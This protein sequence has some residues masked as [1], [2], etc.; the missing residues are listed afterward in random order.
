MS[1][2]SRYSAYD[3]ELLAIYATIVKFRHMLE[4]RSFKIYT[5]Q[6]PLTSAFFKAKDPISNRQ[7]HQLA[8]ISEFAT[9][10]A[11]IPGLDNVVPDA[12]SRQYDDEVQPVVVHTVVHTLADL[13]LA[14]IAR[15][16]PPI[17]EEQPSSLQLR[18]LTFPGLEDT[19]ICEVSLVRPLILVP[20]GWRR[21]IFDAL[22]ELANPSGKA[23][24]AIVAKAY[25]WRNMRRDVLQWARQCRTCAVSKVAK[26]ARPE[27]LPVSVPAK[28]FTHVHVDIV[29]P[30]SPN[31]GHRY[32]LT[33]VDRTTRWPEPIPM[34]DTTADTVLQAFMNGWVSR[35]GIPITVATDRGAQFTS[36]AW[37]AAMIRLGVTVTTTTAYHPQ[38]NGMVERF[39]R[40]MKNALRCAVRTNNSWSKALPWVMLGLRNAPKLDTATS[41]AEV[42][43]C[44]SLM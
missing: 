20:E 17:V 5:D 30:F 39:H 24:L 6:K 2:Q 15:E 10:V 14:E 32:L 43:T 33:V 13:D 23:T 28:R 16:Q 9:D 12:L 29:G 38:G 8:F 42:N 31:Q 18:S 36:E 19:V 44:F 34:A 40:T 7:Q 3:L 25:A 21:T 22:Y 37:K 35:Y 4:G 26:H 11:H 41:A 27:V 1:A